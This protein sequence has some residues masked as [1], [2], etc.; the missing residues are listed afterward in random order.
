VPASPA[1]AGEALSQLS[2]TDVLVLSVTDVFVPRP[3]HWWR[4]EG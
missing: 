3:I 1:V 2:V 4:R